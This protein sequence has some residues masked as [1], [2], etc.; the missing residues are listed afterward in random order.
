MKQITEVQSDWC[1]VFGAGDELVVVTLEMAE[2]EHAVVVRTKVY[3]H[4]VA[5]TNGFP[6]EVVKERFG[7]VDACLA[8]ELRNHMLE[9][10]VPVSGVSPHAAALGAGGVRGC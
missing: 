5:M 6:V 8:A 9:H 2:G 10:M 7:Q 1:K 4:I 3:G